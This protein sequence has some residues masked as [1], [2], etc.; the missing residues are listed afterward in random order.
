MAK[1]KLSF[2]F[3][4]TE[5]VTNDLRIAVVDMH[6]SNERVVIRYH[7][8]LW[9]FPEWDEKRRAELTP[10]EIEYEEALL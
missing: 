7:N 8:P 4:G 5:V 1:K 9:P 3:V 6:H 10:V 2:L